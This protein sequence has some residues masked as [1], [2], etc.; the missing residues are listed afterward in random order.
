MQATPLAARLKRRAHRDIALAQ[1]LVVT[2]AYRAF[3]ECV[4]H[5]GTAIWRCY[6]GNRFSEDVDAYLPRYSDSAG[7]KLRK[8]LAASGARVLKFKA[9]AS[10]VFGKFELRGAPVTFEGAL[11][12]P[13]ARVV[14]RYETA[15]GRGMM[16]ASLPPTELAEEK[17]AAYLD[18]RKV[19]DLYDVFFLLN[20]VVGRPRPI[21]SLAGGY[22]PPVDAG[23]LRATVLA[24]AVPSPEEMI[25]EVREW[26]RRST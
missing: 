18:R 6:G 24:G 22:R 19:R 25:E 11:R 13:P 7:D 14:R 2:E 21:L 9:T 17:A 1:D 4:L 8:G 20:R 15:D 12:H 3:P 26:A 10:T 23:Q 16:V 5:G